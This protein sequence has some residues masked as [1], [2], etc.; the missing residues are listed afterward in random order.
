MVFEYLIV[1]QDDKSD[2]F[3]QFSQLTF[4]QI[5]FSDTEKDIR[6]F[7]E[8]SFADIINYGEEISDLELEF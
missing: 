5:L 1:Q 7:K 8:F 3:S 6:S 4:F 2:K